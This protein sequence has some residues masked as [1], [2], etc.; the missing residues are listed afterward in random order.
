MKPI[1]IRQHDQLLVIDKQNQ[2]A[3]IK[4]TNFCQIK[5]VVFETYLTQISCVK[6]L[7]IDINERQSVQKD[8][9]STFYQ[10]RDLLLLKITGDMKNLERISIKYSIQDLCS[11]NIK[12]VVQFIQNSQNSA[13]V[14]DECQIQ[15]M[16]SKPLIHMDNILESINKYYSCI[17]G[18]ITS[19]TLRL[20]SDI[21][22]ESLLSLSQLLLLLKNVKKFTFQAST[23]LN[24]K[25]EENLSQFIQSMTNIIKSTHSFI[26]DMRDASYQ[27]GVISSITESLSLLISQGS[28]ELSTVIIDLEKVGWTFDRQKMIK[29]NFVFGIANQMHKWPKSIQH[30]TINLD[31]ALSYNEN[32]VGDNVKLLLEGIN[33]I[34]PQLKSFS[35]NL[36]GIGFSMNEFQVNFAETLCSLFNNAKKLTDIQLNIQGHLDMT[37]DQWT[38]LF[39]SIYNVPCLKKL[40]LDI[41]RWKNYTN[42]LEVRD[43]RMLINTFL[44]NL[45]RYHNKTLKQFHFNIDDWQYLQ[46][47]KYEYAQK[48]MKFDYVDDF[49]ILWYKSTHDDSFKNLE[50]IQTMSLNKKQEIYK[51]TLLKKLGFQLPKQSSIEFEQIQS[52]HLEKHVNYFLKLHN[53]ISHDSPTFSSIKMIEN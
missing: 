29:P 30:L 5:Q 20:Q 8:Q 12:K 47:Y 35:L 26:F 44:D 22:K 51:L 36:G 38:R 19:F 33:Q 32:I 17:A 9:I 25:T 10:L 3:E 7:K 4:I 48:L 6:T 46:Y 16:Y 45:Y 18:F 50:L 24:L 34:M 40:V 31:R 2:F 21:G 28:E 43:Q 23:S 1:I 37:L 53:Q 41:E 11:Y 39:Q 14:I 15:I 42:D 13:K 27:R 52:E 49:Q